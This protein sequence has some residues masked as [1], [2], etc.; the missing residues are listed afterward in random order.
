MKALSLVFVSLL[1]LAALLSS[2]CYK[3][4][5]DRPITPKDDTPPRVSIVFPTDGSYV[6]GLA[7]IRAIATDNK[8]IQKLVLFVDGLAMPSEAFHEPFEMTWNTLVYMDS[9]KHIVTVRAYDL[10]MNAS[11]SDPMTYRIDQSSAYPAPVML[12]EV[13]FV[14][15][16]YRVSWDLCPEPDFSSY[17]LF[18]SFDPEMVGETEVFMSENPV[19]TL[20]MASGI[21]A[22]DVRFYR[23]MVKNKLGLSSF[24]QVER[25]ASPSINP[26]PTEGLMAY[27]PFN[28]NAMDES[29][30][31][32]HGVV[33][34]AVLTEDR[35]GNPAAA[36]DFENNQGTIVIPDYAAFNYM[37]SFTLAAWIFRKNAGQ[38]V[39]QNVLCKVSP[40][41]DFVL[42]L[43][44]DGIPDAHFAPDAGSYCF[45]F[46]PTAAPMHKW[47]HLAA[48]WTGTTWMLYVNGEMVSSITSPGTTPPWTGME[49][50][51]GS[52][53]SGEYFP[54]C[55]DE[56]LIYNR[57]LSDEEIE[58]LAAI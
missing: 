45:C 30:N 38:G 13:L 7:M 29:G 42:Q 21:P 33:Y 24:S 46:A 49:M 58:G 39:H 57:A 41:R 1:F 31:N 16:S 37:E 36:Y 48:V 10:S 11:D 47:V 44:P 35:Y 8:G 25:A 23:L 54:G 9:S 55:I 32:H 5:E 20:Y 40:A 34:A 56:V 27:Y 18:E 22:G 4:N 53:G 15:S 43:T 51:I 14:D 17:A 52:L 19:D 50:Y 2:G 12:H 3:P 6:Q 26:I 28:G